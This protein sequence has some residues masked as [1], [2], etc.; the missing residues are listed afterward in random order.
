MK[1]MYLMLA[2]ISAFII[3]AQELPR[4]VFLGIRMEKI[5]ED[6]KRIKDLES[7]A[8]VMIAEV[9]AGS[10]SEKA[11]FKKGDVLVSVSGTAVNT[12][13][14]VVNSLAGFK[15][16]DTFNYEIIRDKKKMKG[17]AVFMAYPKEDYAGL[18]TIY[19]E[20]KTS[21]GQQ[22]IIITKPKTEKKFPVIAFV[23]GIGCYSLDFP[24]DTNRSEV[25]LLNKLSRSGFMC[26]RLEKPGMG[27][28]AKHCKPCAEVSF[29]EETNGYI[30]AIK[31][32]KQ[33]PDVDS[34]SI[35]IIG[36]SMGGVFAPLIAKQTSL[37]GIIAYGTIGSSFIEY[38][39]KT[40]RTI[41]EAY[42]M[43]PDETDDLVKDF[44]ECAGY[45][46][47]EKMSTA[48]AAKKKADCKEFLSIFDLRSRAYNDE[49]YSF[50]IP[51]LWKSY[52]GKALL[53]WGES[54]YVSSK[55]DHQIVSDALNYYSPGN[56]QFVTVKNADHGMQLAQDFSES[57]TSPGPYNPEVGKVIMDWLRTQ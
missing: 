20:S 48:E 11:G 14:E 17:K 35:Y 32:L 28:N 40:R 51:D 27:D 34:N 33:R 15:G 49:L 39:A 5:T 52:K 54:D 3:P 16:G 56:S 19:T 12:P 13:Q 2:L 45:Y 37:K 1:T 29:M 50:N 42:K 36:H 38:L 43:P 21:I 4:R 47:V 55:E 9:I 24:T 22:R 31:T 44:C 26:A 53:I 25:Q 41:A 7:T 6:T 8:G 46:F 18:M 57:R 10:T 30:Q 23:G